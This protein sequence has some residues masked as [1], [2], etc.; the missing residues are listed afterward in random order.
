M[1]AAARLKNACD[2]EHDP[3]TWRP[4][5]PPTPS[6][7]SAPAIARRHPID[8]TSENVAKYVKNRFIILSPDFPM[9]QFDPVPY[10]VRI[11]GVAGEPAVGVRPPLH[12]AAALAEPG[13]DSF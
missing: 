13:I 12:I 5:G 8:A 11:G 4:P 3:T 9:T 2:C 6:S 1:F 7:G 10:F